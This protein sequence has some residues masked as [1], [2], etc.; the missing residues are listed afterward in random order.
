MPCGT[1]TTPA[2]AST[3][4]QV[5]LPTPLVSTQVFGLDATRVFVV[6]EDASQAT[7]AYT[8]TSTTVVEVPFR[9]P[10]SQARALR[11]PYGTPGGGPIAVVGGD[12]DAGTN[13]GYIESFVPT[14]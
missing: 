2:C 13:T 7:H 5:T 8:L 11:L 14:P 9:V 6:G 3:T 1:G 12:P 10:R 4:W